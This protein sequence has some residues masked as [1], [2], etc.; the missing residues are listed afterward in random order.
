MRHAGT[1][2]DPKLKYPMYPTPSA[3]SRR[4]AGAT[5]RPTA[6][7]NIHAGG[8]FTNGTIFVNE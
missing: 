2:S 8:G 3:L 7:G 4:L 1:A 6:A 5:L